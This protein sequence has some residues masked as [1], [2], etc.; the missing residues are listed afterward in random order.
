MEVQ[1]NQH[2]EC[3]EIALTSLLGSSLEERSAAGPVEYSGSPG[4]ERRRKVQNLTEEV[5]QVVG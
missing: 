5:G 3:K 4:E 2:L 1:V